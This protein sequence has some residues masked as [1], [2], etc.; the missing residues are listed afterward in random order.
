MVHILLGKT[1]HE[2]HSHIVYNRWIFIFRWFG[3]YIMT[4]VITHTKM[5]KQIINLNTE[6]TQKKFKLWQRSYRNINKFMWESLCIDTNKRY[7]QKNK[8]FGKIIQCKIWALFTVTNKD[9][10]Y[11]TTTTTAKFKWITMVFMVMD[12]SVH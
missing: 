2:S 6:K 10:L 1:N 3:I 9:R 11:T 4:H 8:I 5:V 12:V 7:C